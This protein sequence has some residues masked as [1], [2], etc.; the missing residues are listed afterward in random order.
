MNSK[1]IGYNKSKL[2]VHC[3][4]Y[5]NPVLLH[6]I[7]FSFVQDENGIERT[8]GDCES[9]KKYSHVDL[10]VMVDGVD[11]DRGS[12]VAGGRG[13]YLKVSTSVSV[14]AGDTISRSV[15]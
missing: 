11:N 3:S 8:F 15:L 12:V 4:L 9:R 2:L 13:Y 10:V 6:A 1:L 5:I 14:V 7:V